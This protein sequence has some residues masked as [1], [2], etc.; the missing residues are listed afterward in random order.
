MDAARELEK[1]STA[2][3]GVDNKT[4]SAILAKLSEAA[5]LAFKNKLSTAAAKTII[6]DIMEIAG[7]GSLINH[8]LRSW[9]EEWLREKAA[10][11]KAT[12]SDF[13]RST[14]NEFVT[15]MKERADHPIESI[16]TKEIRE[17]RDNVRASGRVAKTCNH[18]LKA[19]R[20]LF[21]DAVKHTVIIHNPTSPIK[22]LDETDSV[23]RE[24]FTQDEVSSLIQSATSDEWRGMIILGA[25][26]GL[27]LT[28]IAQIKAENIDIKKGLLRIT[29]MKTSRKGTVV[30][31]PLHQDVLT[32]FKSYELPAFDG[33][34]VFPHLST[35]R[36]GGRNGLSALFKAIMEKSGVDSHLT[37]KTKD[38]AARDSSKRSFHS[39]RH[40]FTS[41]LANAN[42][43]E[44]IRMKMTGHTDTRTHQKYTHEDFSI[45]K[46]AVDKLDG[47]NSKKKKA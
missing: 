15:R 33:V 12:T 27:R 11:T 3:A 35:R 22:T 8:T 47:I 10:T 37:R 44:E 45:L 34:P 23:H 42:V 17:Y 28:D 13:Y 18:K 4:Q 21:G 7:Q 32:F 41:W 29:P 31:I 9:A 38:G 20:S 25:F 40:T 1:A 24:A 30:E 36:T 5:E 14:I 26:T 39:L 6:G 19:I 43:P 46:N 16:T 2:S